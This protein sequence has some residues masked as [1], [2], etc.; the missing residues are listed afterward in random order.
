MSMISNLH[1][2][3]LQPKSGNAKGKKFRNLMPIFT[4]AINKNFNNKVNFNEFEENQLQ[5]AKQK[6][7]KSQ[8]KIKSENNPS[9]NKKIDYEKIFKLFNGKQTTFLFERHCS[10][11]EK[12]SKVYENGF[13]VDELK[14]ITDLLKLTKKKIKTG[15]KELMKPLLKLIRICGM[16]FI[17]SNPYAEYSDE[18]LNDIVNLIT[19]SSSMIEFNNTEILSCVTDNLFDSSQPSEIYKLEKTQVTNILLDYLNNYVNDST[20]LEMIL[21]VFSKFTAHS[22]IICHQ[23]IDSNG[24]EIICKAV[25]NSDDMGIVTLFVDCIWN[26]VDS[27]YGKTASKILCQHDN[28]KIFSKIFENFSLNSNR[29]LKKQLRN[30]IGILILE[31]SQKILISD[32]KIFKSEVEYNDE[33]EENNLIMNFKD[34]GLYDLIF[35]FL[36]SVEINNLSLNHY[37]FTVI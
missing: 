6:L 11:L 18:E 20:Q 14:E 10:I 16:N 12:L 5:S 33:V 1:Q 36:K 28:L 37:H 31:I 19:E 2:H 35:K 7:L 29:T 22:E 15:G 21:R 25:N 9:V 30:E 27:Q 24:L 32:F 17:K 13:P 26:V 23:I 3:P 34:V 4:A 8:E